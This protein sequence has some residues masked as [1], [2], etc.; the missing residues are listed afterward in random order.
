MTGGSV[1]VTGAAGFI[2]RWVVRELLERGYSV[3]GIDDLSNGSKRNVAA[4]AD[5][6][7]FELVEGDVRNASVVE[8]AIHDD[9][10]ACF[11]LAAEI[12]VQESLDDP[13]SHFETNVVGTQNVLEECRKTDTRLG[14][15]G[16]CM[17][18]DMVD[19]D[20]GIDE[21]HPVKPASP[22]AGS[23]LAAEN[24]AESYYHGY[25]LPVTILRPF[26]TYGPFQ[27]TGMAGGVVS[28]FTDRDIRGDTLKIYGDGTQTR[29]LLYATDCAR[30]IV[31]ATFSDAAVGQV[32]NAGTGVDISINE[33]A[34]SIASEGTEITHVEHHHPQSEVQKLRCDQSKAEEL[35]GWEPE[36]SLEEGIERLREWM[37]EQE[38]V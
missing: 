13:E 9:V 28:I 33:L 38:D 16:T 17:V 8:S 36:V 29:D 27:Q 4:F 5:D 20:S 18:Y 7:D 37:Q 31:E 12:D 25:D 11:H 35:L 32:I 24:M 15:V 30:F 14:L 6:P 22:Y 10:D 2:G 34:E 23:K 1:V 21:D 3:T 19:S 26:N